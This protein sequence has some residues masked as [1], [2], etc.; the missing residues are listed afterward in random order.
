MKL[1]EIFDV[2]KTDPA[3]LSLPQTFNIRFVSSCQISKVYHHLI[4]DQQ[5]NQELN[6]TNMFM[7]ET[8]DIL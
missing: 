8:G 6:K 4:L 7:E 5:L 2:T 1:V 3:C